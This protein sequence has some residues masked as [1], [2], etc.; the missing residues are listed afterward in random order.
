M[1]SNPFLKQ[2]INEKWLK[3]AVYDHMVHLYPNVRAEVRN[4][5]EFMDMARLARKLYP[6]DMTGQLNADKVLFSGYLKQCKEQKVNLSRKFSLFLA[7]RP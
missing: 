4:R 3:F 7:A 6:T 2:K 1:S 5:S